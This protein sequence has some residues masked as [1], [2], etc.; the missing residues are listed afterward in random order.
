LEDLER[1]SVSIADLT[2]LAANSRSFAPNEFTLLDAIAMR[3]EHYYKSGHALLPLID[4][5]SRP[6][7][8][9]LITIYHSLLKRIEQRGYDVFSERI[10]VPTAKK[11]WILTCGLVQVPFNRLTPGKTGAGN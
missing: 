8:W 5:D 11:L 9:V 7:L 6:A 2:A 4:A 10:S 1:H 3:A